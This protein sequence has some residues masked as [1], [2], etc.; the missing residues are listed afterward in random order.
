MSGHEKL[1]KEIQ[2]KL[3]K[4]N[5][6][7]AAENWKGAAQ[8]QK[9]VQDFMIGA[10]SS[11]TEKIHTRRLGHRQNVRNLMKKAYAELKKYS[12]SNK[13]LPPFTVVFS[14]GFE[15]NGY[16]CNPEA[17]GLKINL[18]QYLQNHDKD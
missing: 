7:L 11:Q 16:A 10:F 14:V 2:E 1:P 17:N 6:L 3:I 9:E 13:D 8:L 18:Y 12:E 5:E 4:V 15:K